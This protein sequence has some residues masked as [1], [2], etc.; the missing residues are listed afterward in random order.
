M[1][2]EKRYALFLTA[3]YL[4]MGIIGILNHELW[5]DEAHHWLLARDSNTFTEL[6]TQTRYEGHPIL[7]NVLLYGLTRVSWNPLAMQLLHLAVATGAVFLFARKAPFTWLFKFL[8]VFGY[9]MVFEYALVSRNYILG[10]LFLFFGV[11]RF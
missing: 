7:W 3:L 1:N 6:V 9:F 2:L 5:L 10:I 4:T 11:C 8:F